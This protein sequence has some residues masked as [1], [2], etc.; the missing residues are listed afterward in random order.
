MIGI[1][2]EV[3][4]DMFVNCIFGLWIVYNVLKMGIEMVVDGIDYLCMLVWVEMWFGMYM[5][6]FKIGNCVLDGCD[7]VFILMVLNIIIGFVVEFEMEDVIEFDE[8]I[9]DVF[10]WII[11]CGFGEVL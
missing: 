5:I 11:S 8:F 1:I 10:I 4:L 3:I 9:E 7:V 6:G 2:V